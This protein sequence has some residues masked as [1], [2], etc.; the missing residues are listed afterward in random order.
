VDAI[1]L[2]PYQTG[3]VMFIKEFHTVNVLVSGSS[4]GK[5]VFWDIIK[6]DSL[7]S[8]GSMG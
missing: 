3:S 7:S 5:I 6:R 8:I 1:K 2:G 4:T